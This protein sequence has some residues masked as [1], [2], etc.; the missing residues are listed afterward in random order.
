MARDVHVK[1]QSKLFQGFPRQ[2]GKAASIR[3]HNPVTVW[4]PIQ[5]E[6]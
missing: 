4:S 1:M 2:L 3:K 6:P 5:P